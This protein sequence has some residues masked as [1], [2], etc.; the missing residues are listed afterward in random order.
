MTTPH[1]MIYQGAL[2]DLNKANFFEPNNAFILKTHGDGKRML[3]DYQGA[4]EDLDNVDFLNQ[5]MHLV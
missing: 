4:L 5:T 1:V 2:K 3:E